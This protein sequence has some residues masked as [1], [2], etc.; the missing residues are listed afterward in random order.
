MNEQHNGPLQ[1]RHPK[2]R[3]LAI[4]YCEFDPVAGPKLTYQIPRG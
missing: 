1:R 2:G 3:M 4:L